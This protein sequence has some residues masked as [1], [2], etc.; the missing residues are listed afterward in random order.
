MKFLKRRILLS[1]QQQ[2]ELALMPKLTDGLSNKTPT[3][4]KE[5]TFNNFEEC[6]MEQA[7][8]RFF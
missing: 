2:N 5:H 3:K 8:V 7:L 1:R 4:P 6:N